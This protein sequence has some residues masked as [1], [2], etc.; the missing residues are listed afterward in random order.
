LEPWVKTAV[1]TSRGKRLGRLVACLAV[2]GAAG[3]QNLVEVVEN[4]AEAAATAAVKATRS[5]QTRRARKLDGPLHCV[6]FTAP[7]VTQAEAHYHGW[8]DREHGPSA[9]DEPIG[10]VFE[11][12]DDP[13]CL[14]GIDRSN[15]TD[16]VDLE[17][18]AASEEFATAYL[19]VQIV[20]GQAHTYYAE[21]G[22]ESDEF[23][24]GA[25]LHPELEAAFSRFAVANAVLRGVVQAR[26]TD[27]LDAELD[28]LETSRG[29]TLPFHVKRIVA[30]ARSLELIA[31][32]E[33]LD[34]VA[35]DEAGD[36][37][38]TAVSEAKAYA[39]DHPDEAEAVENL[40]E[41]FE[42]ATGVQTAATALEDR[43]AEARPYTDVEQ[44]HLDHGTPTLVEGTPAQLSRAYRDLVHRCAALGWHT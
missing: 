31:A 6:N 40:P 30:S 13:T 4:K 42:H 20:S 3:C 24:R 23:G 14:E 8:V 15:A 38:Q 41:F 12:A 43:R 2:V 28:E 37:Y 32:A 39:A 18:Q 7:I 26:N 22:Y 35:L 25:D 21:R 44:M 27:R 16:P 11:I 5:A 34:M 29:R 33:P 10:G 9:T 1:G 36:A 17:L 19:A